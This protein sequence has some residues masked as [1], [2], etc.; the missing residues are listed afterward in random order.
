MHLP[1]SPLPVPLSVPGRDGAERHRNLILGG[2]TPPSPSSWLRHGALSPP[3]KEAPPNR[4]WVGNAWKRTHTQE[5][6]QL[7]WNTKQRPALWRIRMPE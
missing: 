5:G 7:V 6:L 1:R 3:Q 4:L 2:R